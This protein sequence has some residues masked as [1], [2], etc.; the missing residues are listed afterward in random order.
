MIIALCIFAFS[1]TKATYISDRSTSDCGIEAVLS[2]V[3]ASETY[4]DLHSRVLSKAEKNINRKQE[5]CL[6]KS[7]TGQPQSASD[8]LV[9]CLPRSLGSVFIL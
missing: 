1:V 6:Y 8:R 3:E 7:N 5:S 9:N 4:S 2:H